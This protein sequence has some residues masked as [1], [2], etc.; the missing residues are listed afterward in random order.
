M[1]R[2]ARSFIGACLMLMAV[3]GLLSAC[4]SSSSSTTSVA[5]NSPAAGSAA[6]STANAAKAATGAPIKIGLITGLTGPFSANLAQVGNVAHVWEQAVN[7]SGG[8]N[9]APVQ[10]I[11]KD[12]ASDPSKALVAARELVS[13][14][15]VAVAGS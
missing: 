7:A 6:G 5:A 14:G 1:Q 4:G 13:E 15:V 10:V 12:D 2:R 8:I 3:S 11:V 9:G